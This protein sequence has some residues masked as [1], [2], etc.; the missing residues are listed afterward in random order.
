MTPWLPARL[1]SAVDGAGSLL[2]ASRRRTTIPF[3][4][5]RVNSKARAA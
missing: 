4:G 3:P 1:A 2:I 5:I